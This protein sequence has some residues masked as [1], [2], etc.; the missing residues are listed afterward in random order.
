MRLYAT[1]PDTL[2][3]LRTVSPLI[4]S[5]SRAT[6]IPALYASWFMERL[7][8]GHCLWANPFNPRQR[9]RVSF[10]RSAF[11]V[12]WS[13]HPEP[14]LRHLEEL[15]ARELDFYFHYTLNA[16]EPE[17]LEPGLPPLEKRMDC[18][19][20]LADAVGPDRVIWRFDPVILGSGLTVERL[21]ERVDRLGR[22]LSPCTRT[23]VF[24]FVSMYRKTTAALRRHNASLRPPSMEEKCQWAAGLAAL[25]ACWPVPL[26]LAACAEAA[27]FSLWGVERGACIDGERIARLAPSNDVQAHCAAGRKDAG[28]R[29]HCRCISS[30][31]IG[32]Y[33]TCTL[34]CIYCYA[35]RR[36]RG[37]AALRDKA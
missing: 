31:D 5:V 18:F 6:D 11:V 24:S 2:A 14:M 9:V 8:Q 23:C 21:L 16:Y 32:S 19:R 15:R 34:G 20:R 29:P 17:G 3:S 12:F 1:M 26:Q 35:T 7:R 25:N 28:Q 36:A 13:K 30:K 10:T 37:A 33:D 22:A 27:D 4:L